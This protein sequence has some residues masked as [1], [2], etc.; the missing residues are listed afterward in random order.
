MG[1]VIAIAGPT[2]SGKTTLA[3]FLAKYGFEQIVTYT[4]RPMRRG[5]R[6]GVDYHFISETEFLK[7]QSEAFFAESTSYDATFGKCYYGSALKDF[8][9]DGNKKVIVL[10]P[11]GITALDDFIFTVYLYPTYAAIF[12]RGYARGDTQQELDRRVAGDEA[13]FKLIRDGGYID[14]LVEGDYPV[15]IIAQWVLN[16]YRA[17]EG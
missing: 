17:A 7:K 14:Y 3:K 15:E 10:N 9:D 11:R 5:E 8:T 12:S 16:A 1:K 13:D 4:T 2:C 6:D